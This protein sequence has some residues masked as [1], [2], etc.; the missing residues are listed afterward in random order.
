MNTR[1]YLCRF[2]ILALLFLAFTNTKAYAAVD[3]YTVQQGDSLWKI[4]VK[5]QVGLS[6]I[7]GANPQFKD[8]AMIYPGEKVYVPLPN[9]ETKGLEQQVV[10]LVNK[11]RAS[12]GL[13]KLTIN[14]EL[15]RVARYKSEDMRDKKYF[16]HQS[17]TYGSPFDM[18]RKF[19]IS[20]ST[21]GENIAKGQKTAQ[22]V[23]NAWMNS[24][25]HRKNILNASFTEIGVG[26]AAGGSGGPYWTQMFIKP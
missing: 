13:G 19:G 7:I 14:W 8:P 6:E 26:Y 5:Y 11:E 10:D 18:I 1:K 25:G 12:R 17:P 16:S 21:A 4:A 3:T 20:Y 2:S 23:M 9:P 24:E 15:A 22:A